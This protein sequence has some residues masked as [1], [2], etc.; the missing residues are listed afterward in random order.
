MWPTN[1]IEEM[2]H[3]TNKRLGDKRKT[4][5]K[6][7]FFKWLG[8]RLAMACEPRRGPIDVYWKEEYEVGS[9]FSP[10]CYNSRF[11]MTRHRFQEITQYLTFTNIDGTFSSLNDVR[12]LFIIYV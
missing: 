7:E 6:G 9:V 11:N 2:L 1:T 8:I 4:L 3:E 12:I 10:P 5:T